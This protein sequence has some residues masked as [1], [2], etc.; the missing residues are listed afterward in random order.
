MGLLTMDSVHRPHILESTK[1][2]PKNSGSPS[3]ARSCVG[4]C[5]PTAA[6][7]LTATRPCDRVCSFWSQVVTVTGQMQYAYT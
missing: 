6:A 2:M 1:P 7:A 5:S 4:A 3:A